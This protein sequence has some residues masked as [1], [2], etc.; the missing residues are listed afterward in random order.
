[1]T[2]EIEPITLDMLQRMR[3]E[4]RYLESEKLKK[5]YIENKT[6]N[7]RSMVKNL[8]KVR[9]KKNK[10]FSIKNGICINCDKPIKEGLTR[11]GKKYQCC[12]EHN[13]YYNAKNRRYL[14]RISESR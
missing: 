8:R 14:Q 4:G 9:D 6:K 13:Q 3:K 1:M 11:Q 2:T 7:K 12:E 5:A 10:I